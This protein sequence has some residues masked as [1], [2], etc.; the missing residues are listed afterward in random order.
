MRSNMN[1]SRLCL[2][3][4]SK[5]TERRWAPNWK[6]TCKTI[7]HTIKLNRRNRR[8]NL[9]ALDQLNRSSVAKEETYCSTHASSL[10]WSK[11]STVTT[12]RPIR[13]QECSKIAVWIR[14]PHLTRPSSDTKTHSRMTLIK[15][16]SIKNSWNKEFTVPRMIRLMKKNRKNSYKVNTKRKYWSK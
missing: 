9:W 4:S 14:V 16:T 11:Y 3:I 15:M 12:C 6:T 5:N 2:A 10:W 13:I 8:R 7:C 1:I